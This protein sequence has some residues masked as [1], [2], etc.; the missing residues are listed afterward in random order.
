MLERENVQEGEC[1]KRGW[2]FMLSYFKVLK[3]LRKC[4][5]LY[6]YLINTC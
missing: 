4:F 6:E 5:E 1:W 3:Y 2:R